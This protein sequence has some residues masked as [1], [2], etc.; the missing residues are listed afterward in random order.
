MKKLL[1]TVVLVFI[2]SCTSDDSKPS[3]E[4][5]LLGKWKLIEQL[6]DPGDGSGT[7]LPIESNR[8]IE[9]FSDGTV[10]IN[11]IL[12]YMSSEVGDKESGT[13]NLITDSNTD[14]ENVGVILPNTCNSRSAKVYFDLPLNG[15]LIL[16]YLC[17][18]GCGQK[19]EKI[20]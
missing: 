17:I 13:Y 1:F 14:A 10:Q 12:C 4:K 15:D 5:N 20:D 2:F 8:T 19:F 9:F 7:F 6:A 16:W 3:E 18:E 11:G